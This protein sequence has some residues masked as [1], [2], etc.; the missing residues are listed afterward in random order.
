MSVIR[1]RKRKRKG[2]DGR[3][4]N[5][6]LGGRKGS[7][8]DH[9]HVESQSQEEKYRDLGFGGRESKGGGNK[10]GGGEQG[11]RKYRRWKDSRRT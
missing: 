4:L 5:E 9:R 7:G 11:Q 10:F 8:F 2:G 3:E 1:R 6:L